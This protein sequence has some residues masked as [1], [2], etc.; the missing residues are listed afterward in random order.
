MGNVLGRYPGQELSPEG[1]VQKLMGSPDR[2][3]SEN[4]GPI[5]THLRDNVF[6]ANSPEWAQLKQGVIDHLTGT[7]P[8]GEPVPLAK[9][10]QRIE[11]YLANDRT[12]GA[13]HTPRELAD[14]ASHANN[15]RAAYPDEIPASGTVERDIAQQAGRFGQRGS[16]QELLNRLNAADGDQYA[17]RLRQLV[18]PDTW[19]QLRQAV[20]ERISEQPR[21]MISWQ[22]QRTG[23]NIAKFL[24]TPVAREMFDTN[25][26]AIM[27]SIAQ[28]HIHLIP[29]PGSVNTSGTA[30][31][32][33]EIGG[34]VIKGLKAQLMKLIF[35]HFGHI[36]GYMLGEAIERG[37]AK[38]AERRAA[39]DAIHRFIG[40]RPLRAPVTAPQRFGATAGRLIRPPTGGEQAQQSG[41]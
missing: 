23:Q 6:G 24:N 19:N 36:P 13:I 31:M 40:E 26:R 25:E 8:G 4:A 28:A 10:V 5:L 9:Q 17:A 7:P 16:G 32:N 35:A 20:W 30:Y 29:T 14:L 1:I 22:D 21:G 2:T 33:Q 3:F 41:G 18:S 11:R 39:E 34:H 12:S 15:L 38:A 27:S 37:S